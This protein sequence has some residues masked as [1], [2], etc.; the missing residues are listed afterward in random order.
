MAIFVEADQAAGR[1]AAWVNS[2][3]LRLA[4]T[5]GHRADPL[6][7]KIQRDVNGVPTGIL[8]ED[9]IDPVT[10]HIPKASNAQLVAAMREAQT[11]CWQVGGVYR[12]G[13]DF[14]GRARFVALQTRGKTANLGCAVKM[15]P[16]TGWNTPSAW[17]CAAALATIGCALAVSKSLPMAH[18]GRAPP[19]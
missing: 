9:A 3:A 17:G 16:F 1:H 4:G 13:N 18:W 5:D 8:F 7:D 15:C 19:R 11:T 12:S 14:D 2:R 6:A 10:R